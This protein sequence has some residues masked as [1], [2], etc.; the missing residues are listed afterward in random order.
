MAPTQ[1]NSR[2]ASASLPGKLGV[3]PRLAEGIVGLVPR[4]SAGAKLDSACIVR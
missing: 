4:L 3:R 2:P 1:L